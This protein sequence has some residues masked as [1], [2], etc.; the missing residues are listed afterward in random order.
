MLFPWIWCF[1]CEKSFKDA[2]LFIGK[3]IANPRNQWNGTTVK[4]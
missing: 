4:L 2:G 3:E 1:D